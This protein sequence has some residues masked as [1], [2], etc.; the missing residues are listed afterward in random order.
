MIQKQAG[1][2]PSSDD[3][4]QEPESEVGIQS[5]DDEGESKAADSSAAKST[6]ASEDVPKKEST[7]RKLYEDERDRENILHKYNYDDIDLDRY[8]RGL[9]D[10]IDMKQRFATS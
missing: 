6:K 7:T 9:S 1:L 8:T 4:A 5:S 2:A 10:K 3:E